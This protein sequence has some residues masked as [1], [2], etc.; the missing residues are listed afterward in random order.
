MGGGKMRFWTMLL[1]HDP[2]GI[3]AYVRDLVAL[4]AEVEV[5]TLRCRTD[6]RAALIQIDFALE[7][8]HGNRERKVDAL[9][10]GVAY[11]GWMRD[12]RGDE[13]YSALNDDAL[14]MNPT[15][16][17]AVGEFSYAAIRQES[18]VLATDHYATHPIYYYRG[19][20]GRWVASNDLRLLLLSH[21]VPIEIRRDACCQFLTQTVMVDENE[22][23][24]GT[25]F[26]A[27]VL[28][29]WPDSVLSISPDGLTHQI[30]RR[31]GIGRTQIPERARM[32]AVEC[33]QA[34]RTTLNGCVHDRILAGAG[35]L[36]LSGGVDSSTVL[37]AC[38][39]VADNSLPLSVNVSFKDAD[40]VMSQDEKLLEAMFEQHSMPHRIIYA[41]NFLRLPTSDDPLSYIDGPDAAANPLAKE[42]CA[43]AFQKRGVALVMTGEGGDLVLGEAM[44]ELILD[45]IRDHDGLQAVH[46]YVSRNLA[47]PRFSPTYFRKLLASV[48]PAFGR[49]DLRRK[50]SE[51][52]RL[53]VPAFLSS[54]LR[55]GSRRLPESEP[56]YRD[57]QRF[58]YV[59]NEYMY[60]MLFPR[61]AYFDTLNVQCTHSHPFL[62]PRMI[63]FALAC[64]P[65]LQHD[66]R[67]LDR[68]NPYATAKMLARKAYQRELPT[69]VCGKKHKT[70][71]ALMARRM[72]HNS[73][74]E[75][76]RLTGR[77]MILHDWGL[78][79]QASFRR[80]LMAYIVA[81]E[82][83]NADLGT[84]YHY[85]RGV[86]DLETWLIRFS[87]SRTLIMERLKIQPLRH[88]DD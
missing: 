61:A 23:A 69:F 83:P 36:M 35:G 44:H 75:L 5:Q 3:D 52:A 25:T 58:A 78:I 46:Q 34:F 55:S 71:Y 9:P 31:A 4:F 76:Y 79:D 66:Y 30:T 70:S 59:G 19:T 47:I 28:K 33:V 77:P 37:G 80:H 27:G 60:G 73:A 84:Q 12:V 13:V 29:L 48:S 86:T 63:A 62:D 10:Q 6:R 57:R 38:L 68:S 82:D 88:L 72:F 54:E 22:L 50:S 1:N 43:S 26:F 42:A 14:P 7:A 40:L 20:G 16:Q 49:H 56:H 24:G 2:Y 45:S 67:N 53:D 17:P 18:A 15:Q 81:T 74:R 41:D 51:D 64:P 65:H 87:G 39:A 32:D 85:I 21:N 11:S 8:A